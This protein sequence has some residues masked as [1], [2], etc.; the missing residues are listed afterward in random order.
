MKTFTSTEA[1]QKFGELTDSALS[2]P[3]SITRRGRV[4]LEIM[5]PQDKERMFQEKL[6]QMVW[7]QF[8]DD[9]L[10]SEKHYQKTGLHTT[11][12]EMKAWANSL[13]TST[14][15]PLPQCHK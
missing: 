14:P 1:K 3:V 11:L 15:K 2:E 7:E 8:V 12:D 6:E 13:S 9:A 10:E 5:T 4:I